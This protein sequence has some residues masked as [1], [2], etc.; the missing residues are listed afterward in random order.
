MFDCQNTVGQSGGNLSQTLTTV[1]LTA[2]SG[3]SVFFLELFLGKP[4]AGLRE[5]SD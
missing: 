2:P 1:S 3:Q 5:L 4:L